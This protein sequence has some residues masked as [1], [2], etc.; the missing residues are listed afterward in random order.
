VIIGAGISGL[1][2]GCYLAK[3]GLKALIVE[4]NHQAGGYCTSFRRKGYRFDACAHGLSSLRENGRMR[5][6]IFD[7]SLSQNLKINRV[8]PADIIITP[9]HKIKIFN[10]LNK[11][12]KEFQHNFPAE[13]ENIK[14]FFSYMATSHI[15]EL[16]QAR[17]KTFKVLLDDFLNDAKLKAILSFLVLGILG[18]TSDKVSSV[19]AVLAIR[20]FILDGGYYPA[21]GMQSFPNALVKRFTELGGK[22]KFSTSVENVKIENNSVSTVAL[23]KGKS[24]KEMHC[25][26]IVIT[27]DIHRAFTKLIKSKQAKSTLVKKIKTLP[28]SVSMFMVY[29]G[30]DKKIGDLS[31]LKTNIWVMKKYDFK[32]LFSEVKKRKNN[33]FVITSPFFKDSTSLG[34]DKVSICLAAN[35]IYKEGLYWNRNA[36]NKLASRLIKLADEVIPNLSKNI[37]LQETAAPTTLYNWTYNWKGASYGWESSINIFGDPDLSQKTKIN[38]LYLTGHWSNQSSGITMVANCGYYTAG[39]ILKRENNL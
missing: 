33:Y 35:A 23:V 10:D 11:T 30:V 34:N 26:Y 16:T 25:K 9:D 27:S 8:D 7:L 28:T 31:W 19:V 32:K 2:C 6:I 3:A 37:K 1:V 18:S 15:N 14:N 29:L 22:I 38:N 17:G 13:K 4:K 39:M 36:R 21:E 12:I 5:K 24:S 20:E